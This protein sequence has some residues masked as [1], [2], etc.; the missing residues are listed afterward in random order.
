MSQRDPVHVDELNIQQLRTLCVVVDLGSYSA[1]SQAMGLSTPSL[2]ARIR[3][4]E[5]CYGATLFHKRG[6]RILATPEAIRLCEAVRPLIAG[7]ESTFELVGPAAQARPQRITLLTGIRMALEELCPVL[8]DFCDRH[9]QITL[10]WQHAGNQTAQEMLVA[11]EADMAVMLE[12]SAAQRH[13]QVTI[14][15]A[16][17]IEYLAV[18]PLGHPLAESAMR[19]TDL[20]AYPLITGNT[21]AF[22][23][24]ALDSALAQRDLSEKYRVRVETDNSAV[25]IACVRAGLGIGV[26]AGRID[27]ALLSGLCFRSLRHTLGTARVAVAW[28]RG[29]ILPELLSELKQAI[30]T[31]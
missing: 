21:G 22:V 10:C 5:T 1:A 4:L 31:A 27:G 11:N 12:P 26:I 30:C 16:Y 28:K 8:T 25:T 18:M 15:H 29:V 24:I 2:W 6:R 20:V 17:E 3:A 19:W 9:P 13:R 7:L 14:E 23:R